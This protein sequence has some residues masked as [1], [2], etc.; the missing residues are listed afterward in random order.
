VTEGEQ[1]IA[2]ELAAPADPE[3]ALL[4]DEHDLIHKGVGWMLRY[5]ID[6]LD[7]AERGRYMAAV[8]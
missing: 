4:G 8:P 3:E 7:P 1:A 2:R 5:A 6:R